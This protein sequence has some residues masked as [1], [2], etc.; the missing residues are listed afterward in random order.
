MSSAPGGKLG[1]RIVALFTPYRGRLALVFAV[2]VT[3]SGLSVIG[4]LLVKV[5]FDK[6]LFPPGG[7]DLTLLAELVAVLIAIPII[8][9]LLNIVQTYYTHWIGNRLLRD[10]IDRLLVH[11]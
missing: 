9:G 7:P 1:P 11:L 8:T 6:A 2:I 5:V 3:S 4:A 10:V